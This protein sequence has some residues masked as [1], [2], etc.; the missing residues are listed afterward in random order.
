MPESCRNL[1]AEADAERQL[2][3]S[4]RSVLPEREEDEVDVIDAVAAAVEVYRRAVGGVPVVGTLEVNA[5][6]LAAA[7]GFEAPVGAPSCGAVIEPNCPGTGAAAPGPTLVN[8]L[9]TS[10]K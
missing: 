1:R 8:G 6:R 9:S 5:E 10:L 2:S 4:I 7:A 3:R